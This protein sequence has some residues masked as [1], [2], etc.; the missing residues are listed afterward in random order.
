[1]LKGG[2][3]QHV[4]FYKTP[5]SVPASVTRLPSCTASGATRLPCR[6]RQPSLC[7]RVRRQ[8]TASV[9]LTSKRCLV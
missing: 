5:S 8:K 4:R 1:M 3:A 6:H 9:R 2:R 7:R